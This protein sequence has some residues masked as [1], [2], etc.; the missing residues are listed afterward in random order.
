MNDEVD[1]KINRTN[2]AYLIQ[3]LGYYLARH[4]GPV[5]VSLHTFKDGDI[6][7]NVDGLSAATLIAVKEES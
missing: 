5:R 6:N 3:Q 2:A 1:Y 4:P 7:I